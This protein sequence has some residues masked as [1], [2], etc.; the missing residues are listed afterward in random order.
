[1]W[2][3]HTILSVRGSNEVDGKALLLWWKF[4]QI[5]PEFVQNYTFL[6]YRV[7]CERSA[8]QYQQ[9]VLEKIRKN[10]VSSWCPFLKLK[11]LLA[12]ETSEFT[13]FVN[14]KKMYMP[15]WGYSLWAKIVRLKKKW[16]PTNGETI[17]EATESVERNVNGLPQMDIRICLRDKSFRSWDRCGIRLKEKSKDN[18]PIVGF[19][20]HTYPFMG[21]YFLFVGECFPLWEIIFR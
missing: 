12:P 18:I 8:K 1:M 13:K 2:K 9:I 11:G 16:N 7:L 4:L 20:S 3:K 17:W 10:L 14:F 21:D 19:E 15:I 5:G 6:T